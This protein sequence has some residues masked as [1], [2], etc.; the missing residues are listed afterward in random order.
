M[1]P[2]PRADWNCRSPAPHRGLHVESEPRAGGGAAAGWMGLGA[3][4]AARAAVPAAVRGETG[5]C[6][7]PAPTSTLPTSLPHPPCRMAAATTTPTPAA[8]GP[9]RCERCAPQAA[10]LPRPPAPRPP[11]KCLPL[12]PH[13]PAASSAPLP[14]ARRRLGPALGWAGR[15]L[16][17]HAPPPH[18]YRPA[19]CPA[20]R[21]PSATGS[22]AAPASRP[23]TS[24]SVSASISQ[25]CAS[26]ARRASAV[27]PAIQAPAPAPAPARAR[28][29]APPTTSCRWH[30]LG[31][32]THV[33]C[34]CPRPAAGPHGSLPARLR[35]NTEFGVAT[36]L[37]TINLGHA[38]SAPRW[39]LPARMRGRPWRHAGHDG[40]S[41]PG[42]R[43]AGPPPCRA[44]R[45]SQPRPPPRAPG[46][47]L[48]P[49]RMHVNPGG[50][51]QV[52][53]ELG[54]RD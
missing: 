42:P 10:A 38:V 4:A 32:P 34:P 46:A 44:P 41:L 6:R 9:P 29:R 50:C 52:Q 19:L 7:T 21:T 2:P 18:R 12:P 14:P 47:H 54:C 53:A 30:A 1:A 20:R 36:N 16:A 8:T 51:P 25:P 49:A 22:A 3:A 28:A 37:R 48:H 5:T 27:M 26:A 17:Y 40:P 11:Y 45:P 33:R 31:A 24:P 23:S 35:A 15:C 43:P 13:T 39:C